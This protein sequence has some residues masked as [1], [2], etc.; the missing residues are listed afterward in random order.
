M[1]SERGPAEASDLRATHKKGM[2]SVETSRLTGRGRKRTRRRLRSLKSKS[3]MF[4]G[5]RMSSVQI[6]W[7]LV[8]SSLALLFMLGLTSDKTGASLALSHEYEAGD[9]IQRPTLAPG[10]SRSD[11][12]G[13]QRRAERPRS[14]YSVERLLALLDLRQDGQVDEMVPRGGEEEEEDDQPPSQLKP[15][16]RRAGPVRG[17]RHKRARNLNEMTATSLRRRHR[18]ATDEFAYTLGK[19]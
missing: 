1:T 3:K 10:D 12:H 17:S 5:R 18:A 13:E 15:T 11:Q 19:F 9:Q 6:D 16:T 7:S 14:V 4:S 8:G 2:S